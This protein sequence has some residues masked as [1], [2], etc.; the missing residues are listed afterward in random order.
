MSANDGVYVLATKGSRGKKE[1]RIAH[2]QAIE[3]LSDGSGGLDVEC[4]RELFGN[5]RVFTDM[6]IAQGYA[7][8]VYDE[9]ERSSG[10]VVVYGIV[11]LNYSHIR[12]PQASV[13][14]EESQEPVLIPFPGE[15]EEEEWDS[16]LL[17]D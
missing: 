9:A 1:Y 17:E 13:E 5:S 2:A 4:V 12:F 11:A 10:D 3:N 14:S 7:Q 16:D 6:K 15:E 8:R